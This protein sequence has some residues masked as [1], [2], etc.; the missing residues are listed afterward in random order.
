MT[1][2]PLAHGFA[3]VQR[4]E[5]VDDPQRVLEVPKARVPGEPLAQ[6]EVERLLA[7]V[8][9]RR[10]AEVVPQPDG[11]DEVLVEPQRPRHG[12]RYLRDLERVRQS[13]AVVVALGRDEDLGLVLEPAEGLGVHDPV[14]VALERRPNRRVGLGHRPA[15]RIRA[16]R[17]RRQVLLL[18]GGAAGGE[19]LGQGGA[20][21]RSLAGGSAATPADAVMWAR[22]G[23]CRGPP[24]PRA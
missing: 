10:M 3:Q 13:R 9:E 18:E 16:H 12:P 5:D 24:Y 20:H 8:P 7:D 15:R 14:A 19:G 2:D 21:A 22:A 6:R 11:L 23:R 1:L 4:L 17:A